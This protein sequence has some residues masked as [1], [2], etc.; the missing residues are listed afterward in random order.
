MK[1]I[2]N[3]KLIKDGKVYTDKCL[4]FDDK[5]R[6]IIS[7]HELNDFDVEE[8][9]DAKGHFISPGFIDIHIHGINGEDAS[10][11]K[12][13]GIR[14]ICRYVPRFGVTSFLPTTMTISYE[15][16]TQAFD[17][18]KKVRDS[19]Y[20]GAEIIGIHMEGPYINKERKGAQ[21]A[22]YIRVPEYELVDKYKDILSIIT[23]APE[24]DGA[25]EFIKKVTANTDIVLS[26]GHTNA[27]YEQ[28]MEG[29]QCGISH[30]TH[31][32]NAMSS[33]HHRKPGA[34]GAAL[35]SDV[36]CELIADKFHVHPGLYNLFVKAKGLDKII[37]VT[38]CIR[39]GGLED[40]EYTLGGQKI[41]VENNTS[42]LEDGTIA[43]SVLKLNNAVHNFNDN[44]SVDIAEVI[45]FV[46]EN[47]AKSL[48]IFDRKGSIDLGKD[49]D[50]I[51]FNDN[52]DVIMTIGKG[53]IL[54]EK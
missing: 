5:I 11:G 18:I 8:K 27:T 36:K 14:E 29:I 2:Y 40:G 44:A 33:L 16:L 41:I 22:D 49:A 6:H 51:L 26:M 3:G 17:T 52:I 4:L 50:I 30:A 10:D 13:D 31:T 9:I 20:E 53:N 12:E 21:K 7:Q 54:Y 32:F 46:T 45:Q 39:A 35:T 28:A 1:C 48:G 25:T 43:G 24:V 23:I 37:L 38:D 19:D 15:E 34:V 42:L 47:P